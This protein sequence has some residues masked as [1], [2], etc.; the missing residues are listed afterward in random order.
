MSAA[1]SETKTRGSVSA[2]NR[3]SQ[4]FNNCDKSK[5]AHLPPPASSQEKGIPQGALYQL[6]TTLWRTFLPCE[7][8]VKL[9]GLAF[10]FQEQ[11]F[12]GIKRQ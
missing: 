3:R 7:L 5:P 8:K 10:V 1:G 12:L 4:S 11:S 2:N 6:L 9:A